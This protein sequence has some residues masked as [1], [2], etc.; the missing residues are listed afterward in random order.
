MQKR[1]KEW[2]ELGFEPRT[3]YN[4]VEYNPKQELRGVLEMTW[5]MEIHNE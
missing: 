1:K 4:R 3:S 5:R 2:A